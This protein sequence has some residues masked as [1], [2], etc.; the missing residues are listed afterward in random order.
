MHIEALNLCVAFRGLQAFV[1]EMLSSWPSSMAKLSA[2][3]S[4]VFSHIL[5]Y[6]DRQSLDLGVCGQFN[7]RVSDSRLLVF[8]NEIMDSESGSCRPVHFVNDVDLMALVDIFGM[9]QGQISSLSV[10]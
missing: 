5:K 2:V 1:S 9:E 10:R 4:I 8:I 7:S 6:I 3:T